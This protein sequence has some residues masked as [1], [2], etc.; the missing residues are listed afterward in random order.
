[1]NSYRISEVLLQ[2]NNGV[3]KPM[4]YFSPTL[5][6]AELGKL[7]LKKKRITA[8]WAYENLK[9]IFCWLGWP[10]YKKHL[11]TNH[12][13]RWKHL[14]LSINTTNSQDSLSLLILYMPFEYSKC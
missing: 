2:E 8:M 1:M 12:R 6:L 13:H 10:I 14:C 11:I 5:M 3:L 4:S 9:R 7:R